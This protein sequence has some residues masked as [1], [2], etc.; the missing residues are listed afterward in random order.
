MGNELKGGAKGDLADSLALYLEQ[1]FDEVRVQYGLDPLPAEGRDDRMMLFLGIGRGVVNYLRDFAPKA[2]S[3]FV[4]R[5][6]TR[7]LT[8]EMSFTFPLAMVEAGVVGIIAPWN[9]PVAMSFARELAFRDQ[10]ALHGLLK[11]VR[12][13]GLPLLSINPINP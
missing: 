10:A 8:G 5:A 2:Q 12:D 6:Y 7:E 4:R 11:K 1:A 9:F 3:R 13:L